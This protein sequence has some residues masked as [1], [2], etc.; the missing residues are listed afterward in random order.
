MPIFQC[1]DKKFAKNKTVCRTYHK[2]L[3]KPQSIKITPQYLNRL[4]AQ[5]R[6]L[7]AEPPA[8]RV[9]S[10][11]VPANVN[12]SVF[13]IPIN[14]INV[15]HDWFQ[16]RA[17][18]FS[19]RSVE[20]IVQAIKDG[21]FRW[22]Q[23]DPVTLWQNPKDGKLYVLSGHSRLE[24]FAR[25]ASLRLTIEGRNFESIPAKIEKNITIDQAKDI[26]LNSNTL[27]TKET[28][29]ERASYYRKLRLTE[30]PT[31]K[32]LE[33]TARR[34][35]GSNAARIL[36]FSYLNDNGKT[37]N[38]L[39]ALDTAQETSSATMKVI[40]KWI[41][42]A[43]RR[44]EPL[45][46]S[47]ENELFDF[48]VT[49]K[50]YGTAKGQINNELDFL[51]KVNNIILKR[52][53]FGVFDN[54]KPLNISNLLQKSPVEQTYDAQLAELQ[55]EILTLEKEIKQKQ[56]D[57]ARRGASEADILKHTE[58]GI[59]TL[60][61]KR[62]QYAEM[63]NQK[64]KVL[65]QA[66]REKSLFD[67]VGKI[68]NVKGALYMCKDGTF[69]THTG[70]GAC[71]RHGGLKSDSAVFANRQC[72]TP[73]VK[74][75]NTQVDLFRKERQGDMFFKQVQP[76]N[77]PS[78]EQFIRDEA[79]KIAN[80]SV[81]DFHK[82]MKNTTVTTTWK[83]AEARRIRNFNLQYYQSIDGRKYL[84]KEYNRKYGESIGYLNQ[85]SFI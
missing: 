74:T 29:L 11:K 19:L 44:F 37:F 64:G 71:H 16:N 13:D 3:L 50:G 55:E 10:T 42:E 35:E 69:S 73:K 53:E 45:T 36:S 20:N 2:G 8:K 66:G 26:A 25:A 48:L 33:E 18:K 7:S 43:R 75:Q 40:G 80:Q 61:R 39:H 22:S 47:H 32:R 28:D 15:A 82:A 38:A 59:N 63:L 83:N 1:K 30:N 51:Q 79:Q 23:L 24:G 57:F 41:G 62:K 78:K 6:P 56:I 60:A 27:S 72:F 85:C 81:K 68:I 14:Q 49:E 5:G 84:E 34:N 77:I 76:N 65:E 67:S 54:T 12:P 52:T 46:N 31:R 70:R 17:A 4:R 21:T 58:G 9:K